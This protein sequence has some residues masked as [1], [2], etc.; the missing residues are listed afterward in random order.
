[1]ALHQKVIKSLCL[2]H[3]WDVHIW[4]LKLTL[5]IKNPESISCFHC[6]YDSERDLNILFFLI[7]QN[8]E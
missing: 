6:S 7:N 4:H 1:M 5:H 2:D 8:K 3:L